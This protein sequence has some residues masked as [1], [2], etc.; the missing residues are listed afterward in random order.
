MANLLRIARAGASV[1]LPAAALVA[2]GALPSPLGLAHAQSAADNGGLREM[3]TKE[4]VE[5]L[6]TRLF[7][8]SAEAEAL[9][10]RAEAVVAAEDDSARL[11]AALQRQEEQDSLKLLR[12]LQAQEKVWEAVIAEKLAEQADRLTAQHAVATRALTAELQQ[13]HEHAVSTREEELNADCATKLETLKESERAEHESARL[14]ESAVRVGRLGELK[15][16]VQALDLA[17]SFDAEYK[18][19]SH[20]VHKLTAAIFA[21]E[22][23]LLGKSAGAGLSVRLEALRAAAP[24]DE[25]VCAALSSVPASV[26]KAQRVP[27]CRELQLRFD[28]VASQGRVASFVPEGSGIFGQ[29][30]G[31]LVAFVSFRERGLVPPVDAAAVISRAEYYVAREQLQPAVEELSTLRGLPR[32]VAQDWIE[33]AS[34]RVALEQALCLLRA[35]ATTL[36]CA[37]A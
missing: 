31:A 3:G 26:L 7:A 6:K 29:L 11:Q 25:V 4:L 35:H 34:D 2:S 30:L 17:Y 21:L 28:T 27:T 19:R 37:L 18:A 16:Q 23:A 13:L 15:A 8:A 5:T 12:L 33:A 22:E 36:S 14:A 9:R 1:A 20:A 32:T 10:R 24:A